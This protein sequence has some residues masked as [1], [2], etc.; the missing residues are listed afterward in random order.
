M[1]GTR[2][3]SRTQPLQESAAG[4]M[5]FPDSVFFKIRTLMIRLNKVTRD[6][7]V[8]IST[9]V[10]FLRKKGH[11]VEAS[12]NAKITDEQYAE[13]MKEFGK[14]KDLKTESEGGRT[15]TA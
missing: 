14:D 6:L 5:S 9:V 2:K 12:P 13:L 8:G 15:E 3:R 1:F 4:S 7:N 10:D 11:E